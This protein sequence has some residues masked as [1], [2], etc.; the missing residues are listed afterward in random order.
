MGAKKLYLQA[1]W[2]SGTLICEISKCQYCC[3]SNKEHY[4]AAADITPKD[5]LFNRVFRSN[6]LQNPRETVMTQKCKNHIS[7]N[8]RKIAY[9]KKFDVIA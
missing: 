6:R 1:T 7:E 4:H 2:K 5:Y 3:Q 8:C 9:I